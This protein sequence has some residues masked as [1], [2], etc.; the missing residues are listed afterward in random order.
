M[1][2]RESVMEK[3]VRDIHRVTLYAHALSFDTGCLV[4]LPP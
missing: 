4:N 3:T 2:A 1:S